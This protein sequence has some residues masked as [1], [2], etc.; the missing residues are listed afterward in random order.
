MAIKILNIEQIRQADAY[1]IANEP[2][3]S[4]ML[5]ERAAIA[6]TEWILPMLSRDQ[7]IRIFCGPGNNGGDG[8]VIARLLVAAGFTVVVYLVGPDTNNS[9]DFLINLAELK[10]QAIADIT[11]I[12]INSDLPLI[13]PVDL[14]IDALFGSGL[15]R[16]VSGIFGDVIRQINNSG[17]ITVAI[18]VPS[19]LSCDSYSDPKAGDIIRAAFTLSFQLP[20]LAFFFPENEDFVG[21]WEVLDIGL[22]PEYLKQ[23]TT[24]HFLLQE[25]DIWPL[26]KP[27]RWFA[28][29]GIFGHGLLIAGSYGKMGSAVLASSAGLRSGAGLITA[30]IPGNG[31]SIIQTALPEAMVSIDES[32]THFSKLPELTPYN[33]IAAGPGIGQDPQTAGNLKL[34]IQQT[35]VPLILDADALNILGENKTWLSFLPKGSILTPHQKEF[36]RLTLK[37]ADS[38]ERNKVQRE[39]SLKFEVYLILKG[40]FTC[41]SFPDGR[42]FFNPTGNPGMA[43]GG[44]G[45]VLTGILLGLMCQGYTPAETCMLGVYLHGL[46]GDIA[47]SYSG[48]EGLVAGDIIDSLPEAFREIIGE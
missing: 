34:L 38:F 7:V 6:C 2:I 36:E 17:A 4:I 23:A 12:L 19:G 43:T 14:V 46:A 29:K 20:R 16:P 5:M 25:D 40:A 37:V 47:A 31:Y 44:S 32:L 21:E 22:H 13:E 1:T 18:D 33:A 10:N 11:K 27:R 15:T 30:H 9:G 24:N 35:K 41:I 48:Y 26:I 8:L 42:C 45:D 3:P 39:F 28:H